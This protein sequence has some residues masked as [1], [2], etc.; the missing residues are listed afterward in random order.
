MTPLAV[1]Q[2]N[3]TSKWGLSV[4]STKLHT[5]GGILEKSDLVCHACCQAE[6]AG[7]LVSQPLPLFADVSSDLEML[8]PLE[9][10]SFVAQWLACAPRCQRFNDS[11]TNG[12]ARHK[13]DATHAILAERYGPK[14]ARAQFLRPLSASSA[15]QK[16]RFSGM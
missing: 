9:H 13:G 1:I 10:I 16:D 14:V 6:E 5:A 7:T 11:R 2:I 12:C 15:E 3:H 8:S 4:L